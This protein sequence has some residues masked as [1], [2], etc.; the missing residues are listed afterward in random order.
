MDQNPTSSLES[1]ISGMG[2]FVGNFTHNL[3]PK[4]RLTI[5]SVW[6]AQVGKPES[7]YVIP[8]FHKKCLGVYPAAELAR[9]LESLRKYSMGDAKARRFARA[10]GGNSELLAWDVQGRIR[11]KDALLEFAGLTEGVILVGAM[12][13]FEL[14]SPENS[15]EGAE[16]GVE[17]LREVG[18]DVQF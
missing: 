6:R 1:Q 3:D 9:K 18:P 14:W 16:L 10:L 12:D 7:V 2:M 5:P 17:N 4:R 11:I 13:R 8:D 15:A